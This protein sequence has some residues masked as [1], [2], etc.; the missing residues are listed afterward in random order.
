M[1]EGNK[2]CIEVLWL[3]QLVQIREARFAGTQMLK[4]SLT[5]YNVH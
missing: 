1:R 4:L 2:N 3:A 5:S